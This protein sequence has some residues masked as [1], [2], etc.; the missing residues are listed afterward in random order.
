MVRSLR[1]VGFTLIELLVVLAII[2]TLIALLIP[3]VQRVRE[4]AN[5]LSCA[6]NLK[7]IGLAAHNYHDAYG[8]LPPGYIGPL[9]QESLDVSQLVGH[10]P[11]LLP[12]LEQEALF[13]QIFNQYRMLNPQT[14]SATRAQVNLFDD[15]VATYPWFETPDG[16][17]PNI[18]NYV[19]AR[20]KIK[21][22]RCPSDPER[23][24]NHSGY[25]A[26]GTG[27]TIIGPHFYN[28]AAGSLRFTFFYD[29]WAYVERF[30]PAGRTNYL[31][32]GGGGK[33]ASPRWSRWEGIY[34][35]RSDWSL[36]Q[37]S[38]F[39]GTSHTLMYGEVCGMN[40]PSRG[41][42]S[43][44]MGW[45]GC[46]ALPTGFGLAN[47]QEAYVHQF[48]SNHPGIVQF[49][50]ADGSVRSLRTG[51][52]ADVSSEDFRLL[53]QLSGVKDGD[54]ADYGSLVY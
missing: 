19:V 28:T 14:L 23:L 25:G 52:T 44:D 42:Y 41:P 34:T 1:R 16:G 4:A 22:L 5:R 17:Q 24:P 51:N 8:K 49:C 29:D 15:K 27:G 13:R 12:Y 21:T 18:S 9:K 31:G 46:G 54:S 26:M 2:G 47:G 36:S 45:F 40:H 11:L 30:F 3:A 48:S 20:T 7:Q 39:D 10:L 35:N 32:V 6:N 37:V 43:F 53:M 38:T 50:F 33:G